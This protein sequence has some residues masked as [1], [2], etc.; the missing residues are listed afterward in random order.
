MNEAD[1]KVVVFLDTNA[2][3]F[4]HL[5]LAHAE[6]EGLYPFAAGKDTI[7]KAKARE[8]LGNVQDSK[9]K[10]GLEQGLDIVDSLAGPEV[11]VRVEYS[12]VSEL[13]LM[14]GRAKGRAI[15]NAA[16]E[17][18]PD[19]MW[20]R[21][22]ESE[23]SERLTMADLSEVKTSVERLGSAMERAGIPATV[24]DPERTRDALDLAKEIA[25]LVY[26]GMADSVIYASALV[27]GADC[28]ITGDGYF[29]NTV[30]RIRTG[31]EPHEEI[32]QKL[33]VLVGK[34]TLTDP[35]NIALPE[36]KRELRRGR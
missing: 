16:G 12:P 15:V 11:D 19:R 7:T 21:F 2:L 13:E 6:G 23:V 4:I 1:R 36:A 32:K 22:H 31:Q 34:I 30:N 28:L 8:Y 25:G 35:D 17:G 9:L 14:A 18:I 29:R 33:R 10:K 24:S 27:A 5:Y 26:L 20:T 3:H